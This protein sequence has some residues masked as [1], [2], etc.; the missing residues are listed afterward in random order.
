MRRLKRDNYIGNKCGSPPGFKG[1]CPA[2]FPEG[3]TGQVKQ[4]HLE[5]RAPEIAPYYRLGAR[6]GSA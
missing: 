4:L 5:N 2:L 3:T 1:D 6:R